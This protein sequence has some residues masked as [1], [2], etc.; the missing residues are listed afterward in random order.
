MPGDASSTRAAHVSTI[1]LWA[2][3]IVLAIAGMAL[4]ARGSFAL[5]LACF[6]AASAALVAPLVLR[7]RRESEGSDRHPGS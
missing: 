2:L 6:L 5:S 7:R 1:L 3:A 4:D